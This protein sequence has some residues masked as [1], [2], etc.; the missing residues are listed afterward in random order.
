VVLPFSSLQLEVQKKDMRRKLLVTGGSGFIGRQ[1]LQT[2]L[3]HYSKE[4]VLAFVR[5]S[6]DKSLLPNGVEIVE[7]C[8]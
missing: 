5:P 8:S 7:A 2:L 1:L 3:Q 6:T 4:D